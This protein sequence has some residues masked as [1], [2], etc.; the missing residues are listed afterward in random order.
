[1]KIKLTKGKVVDMQPRS[2]DEIVEVPPRVGR[3]FIASGA[4]VEVKPEDMPKKRGP[5]PKKIQE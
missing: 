2:I 4:A 5:K 1:M 3:E